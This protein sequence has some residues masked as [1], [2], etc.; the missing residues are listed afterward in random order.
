MSRHIQNHE[1]LERSSGELNLLSSINDTRKR[2]APPETGQ[3]LLLSAPISISAAV[4]SYG[5]IIICS[6]SQLRL[7]FLQPHELYMNIEQAIHF[8]TAK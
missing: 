6:V 8:E 1:I 2:V 3:N 4:F 5:D 7:K